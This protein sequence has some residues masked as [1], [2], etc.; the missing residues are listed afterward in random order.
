MPFIARRA[1]T[2]ATRVSIARRGIETK[3]GRGE[4]PTGRVDPD[5]DGKVG[6]VPGLRSPW[7]FHVGVVPH[8]PRRRSSGS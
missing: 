5:V 7:L 8:R 2:A 1:H 3:D 6:R 4:S